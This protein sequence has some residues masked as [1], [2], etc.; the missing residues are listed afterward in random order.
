[1]SAR[2]ATWGVAGHHGARQCRLVPV[3]R[4]AQ[5]SQAGHVVVH[6]GLLEDEWVAG[7]QRLDLGVGESDVA[8][9]VD[10]PPGHIAA[11]DLVDEG[12]PLPRCPPLLQLDGRRRGHLRQWCQGGLRFRFREQ[13]PGRYFGHHHQGAG[14]YS[15]P[16][17]PGRRQLIAGRRIAVSVRR[18]LLP[19]AGH[20]R[21]RRGSLG[22][23]SRPRG[24]HYR[25]HRRPPRDDRRA[26]GDRFSL[27][28]F[29]PTT[30][31]DRFAKCSRLRTRPNP[32]LPGTTWPR[33]SPPSWPRSS[34]GG[35]RATATTRRPTSWWWRTSPPGGVLTLPATGAP[36]RRFAGAGR[37]THPAL[38][39]VRS[40]GR[41]EA[42]RRGK[43]CSV[44]PRHRLRLRQH[45]PGAVPHH[46][47]LGGPSPGRSHGPRSS[48]LLL[49]LARGGDVGAG[50]PA[51]V[52]ARRAVVG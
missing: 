29:P 7:G 51:G 17:G 22:R 21:R 38:R 31:A 36:A 42:H 34:T 45:A 12:R 52:R 28:R 10:L 6:A 15:R 35:G 19:R 37:G 49:V 44:A 1:M 20:R 46:G 50:L 32:Q 3:M 4:L 23:Q 14:N 8:H 43:R 39:P 16:G 5:P 48:R 25:S 2:L 47:R 24:R 26:M 13:H 27:Y 33:S 41:A 9:V 18:L 40:A 30:Q 11:H